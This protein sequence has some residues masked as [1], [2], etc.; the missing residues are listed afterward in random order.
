MWRWL[1]VG[2]RSRIDPPAGLTMKTVKVLKSSRDISTEP[3]H[4]CSLAYFPFAKAP[5]EQLSSPSE[6]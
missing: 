4:V 6:N 3:L 2:I 1:A 5:R